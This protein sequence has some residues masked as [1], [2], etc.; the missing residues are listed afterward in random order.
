MTTPSSAASGANAVTH[1]CSRQG[2]AVANQRSSWVTQKYGPWNSS[3]DGRI[4]WAPWAAAWR[5]SSAVRAMLSPMSG[6]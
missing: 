5:T 1:G 2:W 3:S 4:T 6:P